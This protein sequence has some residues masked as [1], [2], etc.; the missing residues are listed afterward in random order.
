MAAKLP[1]AK[2]E[3][4]IA[5]KFL[6]AASANLPYAIVLIC[7]LA[8]A[9][10]LGILEPKFLFQSAPAEVFEGHGCTTPGL[11]WAFAE[12][13]RLLL[14]M[15]HAQA[16]EAKAAFE[17]SGQADALR[18]R[19]QEP[20]LS[21]ARL[22]ING[23][24]VCAPCVREEYR[25]Q[26]PVSGR[27]E[28][29]AEANENGWKSQTGPPFRMAL[30]SNDTKTH[31][32]APLSISIEGGWSAASNNEMPSSFYGVDAPFHINR[33][34]V[35]SEYL[36]SLRWPWADYSFFA[37]LPASL[38]QLGTGVSHQYAYKLYEIALF[39]API[40]VFLLFSRKL[41]TG[42]R[43]VFLFASLLY[44]ALPT[45]GYLTGGAADLFI[46]GMAP[47]TAA[48]YLSLLFLYFAYEFIWEG[49]NGLSGLL[50]PIALFALAVYS[51]QRIC[52]AFAAMFAA[53]AAAALATRKL[54]RCLLLAA[55]CAAS[56]LWFV[57]PQLSVQNFSSYSALGGITQGSLAGSLL[58][59]IQ[60]GHVFL[61]FFFAAG[62][63]AACKRREFFALVLA[64][65]AL[66]A[67]LVATDEG[68][69]RMLPMLDGMRL[70]P[71]FMLP[72]FFLSG[73][74]A[75]AIFRAGLAASEK[76][77]ARLALD[78]D[79]FAVCVALSIL[80]PFAFL[81]L[82]GVVMT[83]EQYGSE[84]LQ[85]QAAAEYSSLLKADALSGGGRVAFVWRSE[86]SQYPVLD[87][88]MARAPLSY[89]N[90]SGQLASEMGRR[91]ERIAVLGNELSVPGPD[92]K[93][94]WE[95]YAELKSDAA[96]EEIPSRG[97]MMLFALA[98]K[99]GRG[100]VYGENV[101]LAGSLVEYD[102]ARADGECLAE[103]CSLEIYSESI[104]K[105]AVC[106]ASFGACGARWD[107][108]SAAF[109]V[110]GIP[111]GKFGLSLEPELGA[112]HFYSAAASLVLLAACIALL[113]K[114]EAA[115]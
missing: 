75:A 89:F 24:Q 56:V 19:F 13:S 59:F 72:A 109:L 4:G 70:L 9:L 105:Y 14:Y 107:G 69:N 18:V 95:E 84:T 16:S 2:K 65:C 27:L 30:F 83:W 39:F 31:V 22:A 51:N 55:A 110:S 44:L 54:Q 38:L 41:K 35:L 103:R 113:G 92:Q 71:S 88:L 97:S 115:T 36:A 80:L 73:L 93:A 43:A 102:R 37:V 34:E 82:S 77:R 81:F 61:P 67:F 112:V 63:L 91:G 46:Y 47:H 74:G 78:R 101:S 76:L 114:V 48:T 33:V 7:C 52:F 15:P 62:I 21:L 8:F 104:P 6:S 108:A 10:Q 99:E 111:R 32:M 3:Q 60:L 96:F 58:G 40:V 25:L 20:G 26:Q 66:A 79:T 49:K 42:G 17:G 28:V 53:L 100:L 23:E 68:L 12:G 1:G 98:G 45:R 94:A 50:L 5:G 106:A 90:T 29:A 11:G 64:G 57:L 86:V 87:G 85:L